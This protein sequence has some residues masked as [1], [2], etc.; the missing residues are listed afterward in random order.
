MKIDQ[1]LRRLS[2]TICLFLMFF[3]MFEGFWVPNAV[4]FFSEHVDV[5]IRMNI[6]KQWSVWSV[7]KL[8]THWLVGSGWVMDG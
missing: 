6:D 8:P 4:P 1:K 7:A 3:E 2:W 5:L